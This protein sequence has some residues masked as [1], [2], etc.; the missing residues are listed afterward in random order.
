MR[1]ELYQDGKLF[2]SWE[3][4]AL[5]NFSIAG[6]SWQENCEAKAQLAD[7]YYKHWQNFT[8]PFIHKTPDTSVAIVFDSKMNFGPDEEQAEATPSEF[9]NQTTES[10]TWQEQLELKNS[11]QKNTKHS[12]LPANGSGVWE[13]QQ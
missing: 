5:K 1:I 4:P 6:A 2:H 10:P 12:L 8:W 7:M 11:Y 3:F 9:E 13:T